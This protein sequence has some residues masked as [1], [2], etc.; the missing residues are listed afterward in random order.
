MSVI[1]E[2]SKPK[3][4]VGPEIPTRNLS[5]IKN[6]FK[7]FVIKVP[8]SED[9]KGPKDEDLRSLGLTRKSFERMPNIIQATSQLFAKLGPEMIKI[10]S[11][12]MLGN[13]ICEERIQTIADELPIN[14]ECLK[15]LSELIEI[16]EFELKFDSKDLV[17]LARISSVYPD[18]EFPMGI[19]SN[20]WKFKGELVGSA[21]D[22]EE[23][24]NMTK[25][26]FKKLKSSAKITKKF[27]AKSWLEKFG[28]DAL[29]RLSEANQGNMSMPYS[30]VMLNS[31]GNF[32]NQ[33]K[34]PQDLKFQ[35]LY[36]KLG[37]DLDHK[38]LTSS[39]AVQVITS[40]LILH[41][42]SESGENTDKTEDDQSG[43]EN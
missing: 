31:Y 34:N 17:M 15:K 24:A 25:P 41:M 10:F 5:E 21:E 4:P 19:L 13:D 29:K 16:K 3:L 39:T 6:F 14:E 23:M 42:G 27:T 9:I 33:F 40:E 38:G 2:P 11:R 12:Q 7:S 32:V 1:P 43:D 36:D 37:F 20:N 26:D 30:K 8:K 18:T 28:S 35:D 22:F